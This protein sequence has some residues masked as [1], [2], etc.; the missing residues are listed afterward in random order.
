MKGNNKTKKL[1]VY[2]LGTVVFFF[3]LICMSIDS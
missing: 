1:D 2:I 3:T